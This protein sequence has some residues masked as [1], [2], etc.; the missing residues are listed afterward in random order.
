VGEVLADDAGT[1]TPPRGV[2]ERVATSPPV[3]GTRAGSPLRTTEGVETSD[4]E[5]GA[6]TSPTIVD[7]DPI[8]TVTGGAEDVVA[9]QP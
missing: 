2:A 4:G 1:I 8:K 3:T 9:D 6:T 7:V 5:A